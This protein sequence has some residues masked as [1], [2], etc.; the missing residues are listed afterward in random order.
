M[1]AHS[2]Q[3]HLPDW[4]SQRLADLPTKC[5]TVEQRMELAIEL[6]RLNVEHKTGGPFG[7]A[8]FDLANGELVGVGVNSVERCRASMAHA[9]VMAITMSQ[10]RLQ[11]FDLSADGRRLQLL[12]SAEPCAMCLASIPW[13]GLAEVVCAARDTDVRAI[14]FDEGCKPGPWIETL[15]SSGVQASADLLRERAVAVLQQYA[16]SGGSIYNP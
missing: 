16:S 7:A 4:L 9:E 15:Q 3:L 14:G 2:V 6:S 8:I 13:S 5:E 11:N 10:A 12:S 1:L